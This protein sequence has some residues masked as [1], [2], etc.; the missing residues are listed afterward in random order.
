MSKEK[1]KQEEV[2][3]NQDLSLSNE[4]AK[5]FKLKEGDYICPL[6]VNY[7]ELES[8]LSGK[9]LTEYIGN[10]L[11]KEEVERIEK[12]YKIYLTSK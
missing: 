9:N 11:P 2:Q 6:S 4:E 7:E 1:F 3:E 5:S 12:D 8:I 10:N